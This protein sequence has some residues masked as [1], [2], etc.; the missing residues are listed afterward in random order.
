MNFNFERH[1]DPIDAMNIGIKRTFPYDQPAAELII[2]MLP[3]I[4][5]TKKIPK[6]ILKP[7]PWAIS[8]KT[9]HPKYSQTIFNFLDKYVTIESGELQGSK[10]HSL[11]FLI[12]QLL[13][14]MGF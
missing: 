9:F 2:E 11:L 10:D 14:E 3:S 8:W 6:D 5:K 7:R 12:Y 1:K 13:E 4:L